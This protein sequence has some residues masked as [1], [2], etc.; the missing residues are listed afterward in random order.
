MKDE[1]ARR[2]SLAVG[3]VA[4]G[5]QRPVRHANGGN[6]EDGAQV[7]RKPAAARVVAAGRVDEQDVWEGR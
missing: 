3:P 5:T 6:F 7:Q 2:P 4:L 1:R